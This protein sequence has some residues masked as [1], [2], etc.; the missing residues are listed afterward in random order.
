[1]SATGD[2][3]IVIR[4]WQRN[5]RDAVERL[6]KLLA[7][8]AEV[9]SGDAPTWVAV[10]EGQVVGMVTLCVYLTLTGPKAYLDHLVVTPAHRRRGAGRALVRHVIE[11]AR[12]LG[13]SRV[14]LTA[15]D[16]KQA[17][18]ALHES[19]G[20]RRRDTSSFRLRL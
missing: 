3:S 5:D 7:S 20:F 6:L 4:R 8:D 13:A 11:E 12:A 16:S 10:D 19:L 9:K 2:E 18:R 15:G 1:V 17:G 14:D